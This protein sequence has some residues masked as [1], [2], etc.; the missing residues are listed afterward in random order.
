[1]RH[2]RHRY[3]GGGTHVLCDREIHNSSAFGYVSS[4]DQ[5]WFMGLEEAE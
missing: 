2:A 1:M 3:Q 4:N 5:E